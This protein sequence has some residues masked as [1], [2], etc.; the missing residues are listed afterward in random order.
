MPLSFTL[1]RAFF[2]EAGQATAVT[3]FLFHADASNRLSRRGHVVAM[4]LW[5][6]LGLLF[7]VSFPAYVI[8]P[9]L[10]L[11]LFPWNLARRRLLVIAAGG[12]AVAVLALVPALWLWY[13]RNW[14]EVLRFAVSTGYGEISK[15]YGVPLRNYFDSVF[16]HGIS[17]W[18]LGILVAL[19]L[20]ALVRRSTPA[21]HGRAA[22]LACWVL[23]PVGAL[24]AATN[25][26]FRYI[27]PLLP[28]VA[29]TLA[30]LLEPLL[31][32]GPRVRAAVACLAAFPPIAIFADCS[33]G[34]PFASLAFDAP[35][36]H[37]WYEGPPDPARWPHKEVL[38]SIAR[39]EGQPRPTM[40][41][42]N[43]D[44]S[45]LNQNT[46]LA[47]AAAV[48]SPVVAGQVNQGSEPM[49]VASALTADYL[50]TGPEAAAPADW[51]NRRNA[52]LNRA[53]H[54]GELPFSLVGSFPT[55]EGWSLELYGRQCPS[56][57]I[58]P[59]DSP[60]ARFEEDLSL[61][62]VETQSIPN[63]KIVRTRWTVASPLTRAYKMFVHLTDAAGRTVS[64][65]DH[66]VCG[67]MEPMSAWKPGFI[68]RD[69]FV[70]PQDVLAGPV[71]VRLGFFDPAG[72][73]RLQVRS[74]G[75]SFV[76]DEGGSRLVI[77]RLGPASVSAQQ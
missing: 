39:A 56:T 14:R 32:R 34:G 21:L 22:F 65:L 50:L 12:T 76:T 19:G 23:P 17:P 26:D 8:I 20:S 42:L 51:L 70:V 37:L 64:G 72:G 62:A 28:G 5:G 69:E 33:L 71:G 73:P 24:L 7:K 49:A 16:F 75:E 61:I 47:V 46:F 58:T 36:Y 67:A 2:V 31:V 48:R 44:T 38:E 57:P 63:G 74:F 10:V 18:V 52:T 6:A 11:W 45:V 27:A 25:K 30:S 41:F 66:S 13:W 43:I 77:R 59:S 9:A 40:L 3:A 53:L 15:D 4:G 68:Y 35:G 60:I 1:G 29:L 54:A 55:P